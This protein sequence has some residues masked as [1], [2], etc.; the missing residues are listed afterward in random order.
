MK[1]PDSVISF[2]TSRV[3]KLSNT[4]GLYS[5]RR[6][7]DEFGLTLPEWRVLSVV[8]YSEPTTAR[9]ISRILATDKGWIG[10]SADSLRR[11]GYVSGTPDKRDRRR[12]LL[13]LTEEGRKKHEAVLAVS[14]WRQ[15]RLMACLPDGAGDLFIECLDR[16]QAEAEKLLEESET[17]KGAPTA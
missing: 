6:Y 14:T 13:T 5:S 16:L 1:K 17:L 10:L 15:E 3:L 9:E 4:L 12:T 2:L 11:R 7:R 8:A